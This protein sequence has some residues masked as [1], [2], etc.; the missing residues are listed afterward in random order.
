MFDTLELLAS[1]VIIGCG[2]TLVMDVWGV[3]QRRLLGIASLDYA[4]VGRWL[5]HMPNGVFRHAPIAQAPPVAGESAIGWVAHYGIGIAFAAV[6]PGVWGTEW[7]RH[8]TLIPALIV[9]L[10]GVAAPF[11]M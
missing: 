4:M 6:L 5:G 10:G 3:V 8:P 7:L 2:A 11:L 9:G 1:A